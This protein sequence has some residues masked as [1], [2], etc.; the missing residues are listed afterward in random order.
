MT[1]FHR[2]GAVVAVALLGT[3]PVRAQSIVTEDQ[4]SE[5]VRQANLDLR[6]A[7]V[8]AA[9]AAQRPEQVTWPFPMVE[10]ELMPGTIA[11]GELGVQVMARQT[12]PRIGMLRA[13]R[14]ARQRMA[15]ASDQEAAA[16]SRD[17][18]MEARI[19]YAELWGLREQLALLDSFRVRLE[20][21]EGTALAQ[22]RA[23][24][25]P[26]QASLSVQ[27]EDERLA[28]RREMLEE[29]I[30]DAAQR[31]WLLTAGQI[32]IGLS[33]RIA[34]PPIPPERVSVDTDAVVSHPMVVANR[35]MQESE[36]AMIDARRA[37]GRPE[38]SVGVA[39][40]LSP[41]ARERMFG[42]EPIM[43]SVGVTLPLWRSGIR[44]GIREAELRAQQR[45]L[46][47]EQARL[48]VEAMLEHVIHQFEHVRSRIFRY[49][50]DLQPRVELTREATISGYRAGTSRLLDLLDVE[51][52]ALDLE[53]DLITARTREA[54]LY[55][56]L[57]AITGE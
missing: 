13:E 42:R 18:V 9:A 28:Q 46:E 41:M 2:I 57:R 43:P 24:R 21:Y 15:D 47:T 12:I 55:A 22:Y 56:R 49:E 31:I 26:Q 34:P 5:A 37:E 4:V 11:D 44:A 3:L 54:E 38:F 30:L 1:S 36:E 48:S 23:G 6:A 50:T 39:V 32:S 52:T 10:S 14:E 25:G 53:T 7:R 16:L 27:V 19:A 40:D 35:A 45:Q 29:S 33:T 8:E 17:R 20:V 51:R